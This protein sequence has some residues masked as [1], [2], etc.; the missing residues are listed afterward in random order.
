[1]SPLCHGCETE[2]HV[3]DTSDA[4]KYAWV[5]SAPDANKEITSTIFGCRVSTLLILLIHFINSFSII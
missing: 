5:S 3:A 1:M 4:L 2:H